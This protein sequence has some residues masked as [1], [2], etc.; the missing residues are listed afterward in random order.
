MLKPSAG[1][2]LAAQIPGAQFVEYPGVGHDWPEEIWDDVIA[3]M[4]R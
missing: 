2:D 4:P 1:R 3:R